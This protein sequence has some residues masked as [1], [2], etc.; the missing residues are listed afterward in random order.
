MSSFEHNL[1][2]GDDQTNRDSIVDSDLATS[3]IENSNLSAGLSVEA[4]E[5]TQATQETQAAQNNADAILNNL[6]MP[7]G[8]LFLE[9]QS[10]LDDKDVE[11]LREAGLLPDDSEDVEAQA[12]KQKAIEQRSKKARFLKGIRDRWSNSEQK[13]DLG[14]AEASLAEDLAVSDESDEEMT[15]MAIEKLKSLEDGLETVKEGLDKLTNLTQLLMDKLDGKTA[16][17]KRRARYQQSYQDSKGLRNPQSEK[18]SNEGKLM[19]ETSRQEV[20]PETNKPDVELIDDLVTD[21]NK[22]KPNLVVEGDVAEEGGSSSET[23]VS[24]DDKS[25]SYKENKS[26]NNHEATVDPVSASTN[27]RPVSEFEKMTVR[28]AADLA[29]LFMSQSAS[30]SEIDTLSHELSSGNYDPQLV[31]YTV[32]EVLERNDKLMQPNKDYAALLLRLEE[33]LM[34]N[35]AGDSENQT[36]L[37]DVIAMKQYQQAVL[38]GES[39]IRTASP[40]SMMKQQNSYGRARAISRNSTNFNG[41]A[42]SAVKR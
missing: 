32:N 18:N 3:A 38:K 9:Y 13:T 20:E 23:E 14:E 31:Y 11:L 22:E 1:T 6:S 10:K 26:A 30:R 16:E 2:S 37:K 28:Q 12:L 29:K 41:L 40:W 7:D 42:T 5:A 39:K 21:Y 33:S 8:K 24:A 34:A 25:T 27:E 35:S 36:A 17:D 15:A 4:A 19:E